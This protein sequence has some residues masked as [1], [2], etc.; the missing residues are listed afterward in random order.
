MIMHINALGMFGFGYELRSS[1]PL[2]EIHKETSPR[3]HKDVKPPLNHTEESQ[4]TQIHID[5]IDAKKEIKK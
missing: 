5:G 1:Y 2:K 3:T 4:H